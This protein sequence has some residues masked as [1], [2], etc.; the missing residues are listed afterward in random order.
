MSL[1]HDGGTAIQALLRLGSIEQGVPALFQHLEEGRRYVDVFVIVAL[2]TLDQQNAG[3]RVLRQ[4]RG[5]NA[6]G[7]AAASDDVVVL[8]HGSPAIPA[9]P[10]SFELAEHRLDGSELLQTIDAEFDAEAGLLDAAKRRIWLNGAVL[11]DPHRARLDSTSDSLC[12]LQ[13][14]SPDGAA[15]AHRA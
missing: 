14:G 8:L 1:R 3:A 15:K 4:T 10:V 11:V 7:R 9:R 2:P 6:P 12:R 13:I 5:K